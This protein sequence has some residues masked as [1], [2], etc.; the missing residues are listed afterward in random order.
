MSYSYINQ[1]KK[2]IIELQLSKDNSEVKEIEFEKKESEYVSGKDLKGVDGITF[3]FLNEIKNEPTD[4]GVK[5][6]GNVK[7]TNG[8][9]TYERKLT[10]NQQ[11]INF[12]IN[13]F[14]KDSASW[15]G[16]KVGIF[17]E[18]IKGNESIRFQG[19]V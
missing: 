11:N 18:T 14:G 15:V 19:A 6:R 3:E 12:L 10:L 5:A 8:I 16:K 1:L 13:A 2:N 4:F 9:E 7:V 17:T